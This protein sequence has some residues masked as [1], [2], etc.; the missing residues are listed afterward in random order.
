MPSCSICKHDTKTF[1]FHNSKTTFETAQVRCKQNGGKLAQDLDASTYAAFLR[2]CR[3]QESYWIGLKKVSASKCSNRASS[4]YQWIGR[5]VCS[6]GSLLNLQTQPVN[7][8]ECEAV[9]I[10]IHPLDN[11]PTIPRARVQNCNTAN[12]NYI[13]QK[14]KS[15]TATT[16]R[17]KCTLS[18][19][20][21]IK[22]SPKTLPKTT[23]VSSLADYK[24]TDSLQSKV[25]VS[26][27]TSSAGAIAGALISC[28]LL[29]LIAAFLLCFR[30]K[31]S[32]L[33]KK[34]NCFQSMKRSK[35]ATD[36]TKIKKTY[37][38]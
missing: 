19:C 3:D 20:K 22:S 15:I 6:D 4:G 9:T 27:S 18:S 34:L 7:N 5:E 10:E 25:V 8:N 17:L 26:D 21:I 35:K 23:T 29:L 38:T 12:I 37:F 2:C 16:Q 13:C 14:E 36:K 11:N 33:S 24:A 31:R 1:T 28:F 30:K 32:N